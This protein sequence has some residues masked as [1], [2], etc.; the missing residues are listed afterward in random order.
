MLKL[1]TVQIISPKANNKIY[2]DADKH[3]MQTE[4]SHMIWNSEFSM[5]LILKAVNVKEI[6]VDI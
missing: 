6:S 5:L 3:I 2:L 4:T 1:P